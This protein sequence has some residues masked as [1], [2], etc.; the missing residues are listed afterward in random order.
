MKLGQTSKKP[1]SR[2]I[3]IL[4]LNHNNRRLIADEWEQLVKAFSLTGKELGSEVPHC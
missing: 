4:K 1:V 3:S 2:K